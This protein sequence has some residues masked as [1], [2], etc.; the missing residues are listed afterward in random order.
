MAPLRGEFVDSGVDRFEV[1]F[2]SYVGVSLVG[3]VDSSLDIGVE[4]T[5]EPSGESRVRAGAP[6]RM[7]S[8]VK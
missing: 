8:S 4:G 6:G 5:G 7:S 3:E 2:E 1:K